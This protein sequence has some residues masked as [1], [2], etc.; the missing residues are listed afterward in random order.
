[1][2]LKDKV[3]I[4]SGGGRGIG[5]A[6]ALDAA[7]Q[8]ARVVVSD[9]GGDWRGEGQDVDPATA[10]VAEIEAA[11]G[12]ALA[13][14]GDITD[15]ASVDALVARTVER[16]G[17]LDGTVATAG[18]LR[19]RM[20]FSMEAADFDA[21]VA[22]HLRGHFLLARA[23]SRFWRAK[24]KEAGGPVSGS[25]VNVASEAG[26]YGNVGQSNYSAAKGGIISMTYTIANE[27]GRLGVRA[28]VIA[29]RARTR[30]TEGTFGEIGS[31]GPH[32]WD[33]E[34]VVPLVTFLLSDR[35]SSTSGQLFVVGGGILQLIAP[36]TILSEIATGDGPASPDDIEAFLVDTLGPESKPPAFPDLGL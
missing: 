32:P 11:G 26:I 25:I 22:V 5:R 24:S 9:L 23:A 16:W 4:V 21:V 20:V 3:I 27:L 2:S 33:P 15:E 30:L 29:P 14:S 31:G 18:F 13:D 12:E 35:G 7:A 8:G 19:D 1:M 36:P 34:N 28:N 10:V 17:H 6:V